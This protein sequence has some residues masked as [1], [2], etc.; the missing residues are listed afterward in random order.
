MGATL[1]IDSIDQFFRPLRHLTSNLGY[2]FHS[3]TTANL[4][5]AWHKDN[6]F[7]LHWD[8]QDTL[9]VQVSGRKRWKVYSPTFRYPLPPLNTEFDPPP[10]PSDKP[11][12]DMVLE[13][14][15]LLHLPRGHWHVAYPTNEPSLHLT[16]TVAPATGLDFLKWIAERL[17]T[18]TEVRMNIPQF[19]LKSK[20]K[21]W[22]NAIR[23]ICGTLAA[24][25]SITEFL[26]VAGRQSFMAPP[27]LNCRR[28]YSQTARRGK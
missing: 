26:A 1:I 20:R 16:I 18:Q 13:D 23:N 7:T 8:K 17:I 15:H 21:A 4:Y 10:G 14:G 9:I 6:G 28:C 11:I 12:F 19:G 5:A 22:L 2:A 24:A 25:M 3:H 27:P